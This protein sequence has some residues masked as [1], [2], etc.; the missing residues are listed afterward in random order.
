M[1]T[2]PISS[3]GF[4][5]VQGSSPSQ[6]P[7]T[8]VGTG[9]GTSKSTT[10]GTPPA[11]TFSASDQREALESA[12]KSVENFVSLSN[13]NLSFSVDNETD[14]LVV[15]VMDK[16]TNEVIRQ[17]PSEELLQLSKSLDKLQGLLLKQSA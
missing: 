4:G 2:Q 15:K 1:S 7:V 12:A 3:G 8:P 5:F 6:R 14:K 17:F 10:S 16:T 9:T 11:S 13:N